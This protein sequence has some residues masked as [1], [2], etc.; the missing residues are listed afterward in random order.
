[1]KVQ[2]ETTWEILQ[3]LK[4][5]LAYRRADE[6]VTAI[7]GPDLLP[8][9]TSAYICGSA[10]E[11]T[12]LVA[13]N[14]DVGELI[15][16]EHLSVI[17]DIDAAR[18]YPICF[19][20]VQDSD[21]PAGYVK[22]QF[23]IEGVPQ[24]QSS[25]QASGLPVCYPVLDKRNRVVHTIFSHAFMPYGS[26]IHGS[27]RT[28]EAVDTLHKSYDYVISLRCRQWPDCASEWLTRHRRYNWPSRELI[29]HFQTLGCFFVCVGHPNSAEADKEWRISF[30]LQERHLVSNFNCVQ[31]NCYIYLKLIKKYI[32]YRVVGE[33]S[34]TS[35]HCKTCMLYMIENSPLEFWTADRFLL[36][37]HECLEEMLKYA[38][39]GIYP[40]YFST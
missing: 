23:V 31:L 22:L 27:A 24:F 16:P 2:V 29:E 33:N 35:Y 5:S 18:Q 12:T 6:E 30:S 8:Y 38:E 34:L 14:S 1:M 36:C 11:G 21:T 3:T 39:T 4:R 19:L 7:V 28:F 25:C 15:V 40:N 37:V 13:L 20:M 26:V 17:T 32:I 10:Y 9:S